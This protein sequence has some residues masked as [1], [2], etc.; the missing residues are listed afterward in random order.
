MT[1]AKTA[2]ILALMAAV[3]VAPQGGCVAAEPS[4]PSV[5]AISTV[6]CHGARR[7]RDAFASAIQLFADK[8]EFAIRISRESPGDESVLIQLWRKDVKFI[9]ANPE[10]RDEF[11]ISAYPTDDRLAPAKA[12][13]D[14]LLGALDVQLSSVV[15]C[16]KPRRHAA[17]GPVNPATAPPAGGSVQNQ[18]VLF[19]IA[20]IALAEGSA[21]NINE[22][23]DLIRIIAG[24]DRAEIE[25]VDER[26]ILLLAELLKDPEN[27]VR[28]WVAAA[29]AQFG[30]R[31]EPALPALEM[32]YRQTVDKPVSPDL[33]IL[34]SPSAH[35]GIGYAIDQIRSKIAQRRAEP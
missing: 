33:P 17:A 2:R 11:E 13:V 15:S 4:V 1:E 28:M 5:E 34:P 27:G 9:G 6:N 20:T 31:A 30:Y 8:H 24:W 29:I 7:Q 25:S 16:S 3:A 21:E 10:D 32:A 14:D 18:E 19:R 35:F 22:T 12:A 23:E 26:T